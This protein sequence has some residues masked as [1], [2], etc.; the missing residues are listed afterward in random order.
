M[1]INVHDVISENKTEMESQRSYAKIFKPTILRRKPVEEAKTSDS[2]SIIS[3]N[4]APAPLIIEK[5]ISK[6]SLADS[7][8]MNSS[9]SVEMGNINYE[10]SSNQPESI[11][12]QNII[13]FDFDIE[14]L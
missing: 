9:K 11:N 7:F 13:Q 6:E 3:S 12:H 2:I 10:Y 8:E 1:N 14:D 4:A 5:M